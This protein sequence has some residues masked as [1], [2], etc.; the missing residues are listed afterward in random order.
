MD[1]TRKQQYQA[2]RKAFIENDTIEKRDLRLKKIK[3]I[4]LEN[5]LRWTMKK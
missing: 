1:D 3:I 2:A 5:N 4:T